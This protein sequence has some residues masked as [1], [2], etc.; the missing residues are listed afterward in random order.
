MRSTETRAALVAVLMVACST[1]PGVTFTPIDDAPAGEAAVD[2]P[3]TPDVTARP[4]AAVDVAPDL[5]T[6][7]DVAPVTRDAPEAGL[8]P[9]AA[10]AAAS[11][12]A[13]VE[14]LPVDIIWMVDNS[15]SMAPAVDQVIAGLNRFAGLV[16][17]RGLDYRVVMLSLRNA[18]RNV[19]VAGSAR[20]AVC[21]PRPLAGNDQCGNGERFFHSSI[22]VKS[23]QPLEQLLGTLGQTRGYTAAE[24][25]GGEA[26]RQFLRP[27]ATKTVVLVTDDNS[28]LTPDDFER[29]RGGT[30]PNN[31]SL[32]LPPG[33]L[34]ASWAGLFTGY[35]FSAIYGWGS[36]ADPGAR[37]TYANGTMPPSPGPAYTTLVGRTN[38]VRARVCDGAGAWTP[39]FESVATAVV[40][41]SRI[42]CDL[43]I[44]PVPAGQVLDPG[45]INVVV[46]STASR[47]VVGNVR[48]RAACGA[49]GGWYYDDNRAPT[50]VTLCPA[51]CERTQQE[52]ASGSARIEV[53][54]GCQT[55]PG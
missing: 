54:F 22:D 19:T 17:T 47:A 37:C 26:W 35:T 44:P 23:T 41:A 18:T 46:T 12:M 38:G 7:P 14:R 52:L 28:R 1:Q 6:Y 33:I 40:R 30:N 16:G 4:D 10:C 5:A 24:Q 15:V 50:R 36:D 2:A 42:S 27:S 31:S 25:R 32:S 55:I 8:T 13:S 43:A 48:D 9:D 34:D 21:I 39:F 51:T 3:A 45:R 53:Q 29:F 49:T 20:Y 11:V